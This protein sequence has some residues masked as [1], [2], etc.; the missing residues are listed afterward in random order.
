MTEENYEDYEEDYEEYNESDVPKSSSTDG[1]SYFLFL[2]LFFLFM[3]NSSTFNKYFN[4]FEDEM[5][6]INKIFKTLNATADGLKIAFE[7]P[8]KV[9]EELNKESN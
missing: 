3:C 9:V 7:T 2:I 4:E 8:Q 5:A 6:Y 1:S